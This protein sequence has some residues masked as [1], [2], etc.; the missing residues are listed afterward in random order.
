MVPEAFQRLVGE[1]SGS[2]RLHR[3]WLNPPDVSDSP[4]TATVALVAKG[5]FLTISYTWAM[6]G[7]SHEG[8]M[9]LGKEGKTTEVNV[10][11]VDSFHM[12]GKPLNSVGSIDGDRI[13]VLGSYAAPPGP[14]WGWRTVLT[15]D[16]ASSFEIVMYNVEP[17][18]EPTVAYRNRY[19]R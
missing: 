5:K 7:T 6:D 18:A 9:L 12:S 1:W 10:S 13:E 19:T 14:D 16:G 2:S 17:D 15:T 3:D 8:F 4:S 11:W